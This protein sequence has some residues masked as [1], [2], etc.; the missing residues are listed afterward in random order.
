MLTLPGGSFDKQQQEEKE[1]L[2]RTPD[3]VL[4]GKLDPSS[5]TRLDTS[6]AITNGQVLL[7]KA[8]YPRSHR[9]FFDQPLAVTPPPRCV[10]QFEGKQVFRF[11]SFADSQIKEEEEEAQP[12]K[13]NQ[14]VPSDFYDKKFYLTVT[15]V[16]SKARACTDDLPVDIRTMRI[17]FHTN[18]T[19]T[20]HATNKILRGR[21]EITTENNNALLLFH[22]SRFG[23]GKSAPGSVYSEGP[24][25]SHDDERT[26]VGSWMERRPTKEGNTD[27]LMHVQG[28]VLFGTD[29][30]EDA[31]P[32]P[33]G[34]FRL[35]PV[36]DLSLEMSDEDDDQ[37]ERNV[38]KT[39]DWH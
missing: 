19:F 22:V 38:P 4:S 1:V 36:K 17:E 16:E 12:N 14:Y 7:G 24:G 39:E 37:H 10:A 6:M 9:C 29:L 31:R 3:I 30:G 20:C 13:G 15:P 5:T 35:W 27:D 23:A 21:Y 34:N 26:Y 32:E 25:L 11:S 8:M 18:H 28:T 33:V 2:F